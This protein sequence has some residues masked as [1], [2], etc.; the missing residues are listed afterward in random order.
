V[1][2][3]LRLT[4]GWW[5][6]D[7]IA[8][9]R[10][11]DAQEPLVLAPTEV[12][13]ERRGGRVLAAPARDAAALARLRTGGGYLDA[14]PGDGY[15]IAFDIPPGAHEA[16]VRSRGYYLEWMRSAW[17]EEEDPVALAAFFLDPRAALR[18]LAPDFHAREAQLDAVF[19]RSRFGAPEA[20]E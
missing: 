13:R 16:F 15:A 11:G 5:R 3:R 2:V 9:V 8:S 19:W 20:G 12:R 1:E 10:I 18:R 17:L 4:R 6:I 7:R 14:Y